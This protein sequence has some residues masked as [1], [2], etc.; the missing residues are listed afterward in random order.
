MGNAETL[1]RGGGRYGALGRRL[2]RSAAARASDSRSRCPRRRC[3]PR[4]VW[5]RLPRDAGHRLRNPR[6]G[7]GRRV[8]RRAAD[9]LPAQSR[10]ALEC[11]REEPEQLGSA[12]SGTRSRDRGCTRDSSHLARLAGDQQKLASDLPWRRVPRLRPDDRTRKPSSSCAAALR[13][14]L[15]RSCQS[16]RAARSDPPWGSGPSRNPIVAFATRCGGSHAA[17]GLVDPPR[18]AFPRGGPAPSLAGGRCRAL[19]LLAVPGRLRAAS[20]PRRHVPE[21]AGED[22][23]RCHLRRG[24]DPGDRKPDRD[25]NDDADR[26]GADTCAALRARTG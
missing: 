1:D 20:P 17:S 24:R 15:V 22:R 10:G 4:P 2:A 9:L 21:Y 11:P 7:P 26:A 5:S 13:T 25:P 6:S 8:R 18:H 23:D 19:R 3:A 14:L 12:A 16:A